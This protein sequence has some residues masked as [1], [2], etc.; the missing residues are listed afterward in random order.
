MKSNFYDT[1]YKNLRKPVLIALMFGFLV[2]VGLNISKGGLPSTIVFL[3]LP[4]L[5]AGIIYMFTIPKRLLYVVLIMSFL[6]AGITRYVYVGPLGLSTDALLLFTLLALFFGGWN[7]LD[8]SPAKNYLTWLSLIWMGFTIMQIGNPEAVSAAAWFYAM[9]AVALYQLLFIPAAMILLVRLKDLD[10]FLKIWMII[11]ILSV[12]KGF[13][14]LVFGVDSYEQAWLDAGNAQTHVLFGRLRV[15]SFYSDAGQ[16]GAAMAH[17]TLSAGIIAIGP[18]TIRKK[19]FFGIACI[20]TLLGMFISGTRGALAVPA[21]G[22]V[23]FLFLSK[24]FKLFIGGMIFGV[25]IFFMLKFT[26]IGSGNAQIQRMRTA[27]DPNDASLQVRIENQKKLKV[28]LASRPLGGGVGSA[29]FWGLRFSPN[30]FLAQT[31]TDSWF[32]K[33]W[34]EM[35]VIGLSLHLFVLFYILIQ[36]SIIIWSKIED[37]EVRFIMLAL[38][39]GFWGIMVASY[40]NQILG[41]MPTLMIL[42]FSW[43]FIQKAPSLSDEKK[44]RLP[45]NDKLICISNKKDDKIYSLF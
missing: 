41:Q 3:M 37:D 12:L 7:A 42:L 33:I 11:S 9:R 15:F 22:A 30:T 19:I 27:L 44:K 10:T 26:S 40:G 2:F 38:V 34:A 36:S 13:Q 25:M 24:N 20:L 35:G 14:Q 43:V 6:I 5:V 39:A 8:W 4:F 18:G 28:Y 45:E 1:G 17:A 21:M 32:V 23:L 31:P 29:G 16:Y